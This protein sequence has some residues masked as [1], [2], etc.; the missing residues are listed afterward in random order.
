MTGERGIKV[1]VWRLGPAEEDGPEH[2]RSRRH[3]AERDGAKLQSRDLLWWR[4]PRA[5]VQRTMQC[6]HPQ[7]GRY[8]ATRKK[9]FKLP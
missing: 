4:V 3:G 8:T 2:P 7:E 9:E 1:Q 5:T 6:V